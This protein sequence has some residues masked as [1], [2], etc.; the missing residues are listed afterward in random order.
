M[1]KRRFRIYVCRAI[2]LDPYESCEI[3]RAFNSINR[4]SQEKLNFLHDRNIVI[5]S[6]SQ[7]GRTSY[8]N[9]NEPRNMTTLTAASPHRSTDVYKQKVRKQVEKNGYRK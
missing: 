4:L 7:P 6:R 5:E 9:T 8:K 1:T 2:L 3:F